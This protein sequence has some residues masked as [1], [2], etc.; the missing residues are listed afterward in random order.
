MVPGELGAEAVEAAAVAVDGAVGGRAHEEL[1]GHL[2]QVARPDHAHGLVLGEV[3]DLVAQPKLRVLA[4]GGV[5]E[6]GRA[7]LGW[8]CR[9]VSVSRHYQAER[10]AYLFNKFH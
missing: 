9:R 5:S 3:Q 7:L 2:D 8:V 6:R 10:E 1:R 4:D